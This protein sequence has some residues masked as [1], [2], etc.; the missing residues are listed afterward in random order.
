MIP[1]L[2]HSQAWSGILDP[3]RAIDWSTA[4]IPGGIPSRSKTC[5][6]LNASSYGNG[7]TDATSAI[8]SALKSC[9]SGEVVS[10]SAGTFLM[11]GN[12]LIPGNVTL[13]GQGADQTILNAMGTVG[14]AVVHMGAAAGSFPSLSNQVS[15]TSQNSKGD[16][17]ITVSNAT[18]IT[19]GTM[20]MISELNDNTNKHVT[21]WGD[22][23]NCSFCA[24]YPAFWNGTRVAGQID[25]VTNVR[26]TTLTLEQPLFS[27]Y[28][29]S[30]PD[31][32]ASTGYPLGAAIHPSTQPTHVYTQATNNTVNP[33]TCT[34]SSKPPA[35][36]TDG[37]T[38]ADGGCSWKDQGA[39]T[40]TFPVAVHFT[41]VSGSGL[42]DLQI[43]QN[44]TGYS[45]GAVTLSECANCW[46]SG[47]ET[48]YADGFILLDSVGYHNEIVNNYLSNAFTHTSGTD[49]VPL[50]GGG[51]TTGDLL[52]NNILERLGGGV[53][54]QGGS[55]G[56]VI[57]YNYAIGGLG[58]GALNVMPQE[59]NSHQ[60]H[61]EFN[62]WEGNVG[63]AMKF[64][65]IHGSNGYQTIYRSWMRGA[66][67][68]CNPVA[69]PQ[70]AAP[71]VASVG[72]ASTSYAYKVIEVTN[73]ALSKPSSA[74]TIAS[75]AAILDG[76]HYNRVT[77]SSVPGS[78][79]CRIYR[80]TSGGTPPTTGYIGS[81]DCGSSLNDTGLAGDS[82][83]PSFP[84]FTPREAVTCSPIG[85]QGSPGVNGWY[86]DQAAR[87]FEL[88]ANSSFYN[89]LGTILG[90]QTLIKLGRPRHLVA[91]GVCGGPIVTNCGTKAR[92]YSPDSYDLN[93][94]FSNSGDTG[95]PGG[96]AI[97]G[98]DNLIPYNTFFEHG[99]YT[100][101]NGEV[102]WAP[103]I[104]HT[105]PPSLYLTGK[106]SWWGSTP[107]PAIGPDVSGG[108]S[109]SFG[110]AH[111]IPAQNCYYDVMGG[112]DTSGS[113]L[114]FNAHKCY[115]ASAS[116]TPAPPTKVVAVPH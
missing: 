106:P 3:S 60:A 116:V 38:V 36:A 43:Y 115:S 92:V 31:W 48:N 78:T 99:V 56:N 44:N 109:D 53:F 2:A 107:Y 73:Q 86:G 9:P 91:Y 66:S 24:T 27:A 34:T 39:A 67:L 74:T 75:G 58:A 59:W 5:A 35:F 112:T 7:S 80:T 70:P 101:A 64:D 42:E 20:L 33:F 23:G 19:A 15:I 26:G 68:V 69:V 29:E 51:F 62:L 10:L 71:T 95:Q 110:Y 94:G 1:M 102:Y 76:A 79:T 12:V 97:A 83:N 96:G 93:F 13:R 8:N 49:S 40:D 103:N 47:V 72:G 22:E 104:T 98:Y 100:E 113:P 65:S 18:G 89:L 88:D 63:T 28:R 90:S 6:T 108:T 61:P 55:S 11:K 41:A 84:S 21:I 50:I 111:N 4:G 25:R 82:K 52:Q 105:L 54:V 32:Q 114:T 57:A 16:T 85:K 77:T 81:V 17:S 45:G 14:G 37:S 46:V 87:L 30:L